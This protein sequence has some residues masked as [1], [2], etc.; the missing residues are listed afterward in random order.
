M[1]RVGGADPCF[2]V[3]ELPGAITMTAYE[4]ACLETAWRVSGAFVE[5]ASALRPGGTSD[6]WDCVWR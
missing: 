2:L 5:V 3:R 1:G 6:A 4:L